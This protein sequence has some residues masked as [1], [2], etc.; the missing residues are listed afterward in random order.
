MPPEIGGCRM[1]FPQ[2]SRSETDWIFTIK[3]SYTITGLEDTFK[4]N[5][6]CRKKNSKYIRQELAL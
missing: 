1:R 5:I 6:R 2:V 4:V 3:D